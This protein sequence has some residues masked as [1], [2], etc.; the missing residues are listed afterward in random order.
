MPNLKTSSLGRGLSSLIPSKGAPQN[1]NVVSNERPLEEGVLVPVSPAPPERQNVGGELKYVP[2]HLV[3]ANPHQPRSSF[4]E[5]SLEEMTRSVKE[6]GILQ[7]LV[8]TAQD[9]GGMNWW[10][11]NADCGRRSAPVLTRCR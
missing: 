6:Q 4:A 7:P 10:W 8:V 9:G 3:S 11:A 2:I 1:D 5:E